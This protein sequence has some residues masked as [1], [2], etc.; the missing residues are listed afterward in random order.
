[1]KVIFSIIKFAW[2]TLNFIRDLVMNIVF[3]VFVL[4]L[5]TALPFVVGLD[6]QTVALKGDQGALYLNLDGYLADNRDNQGGVKTLLKELDNQHIPQQYSTFDVVYAIDSAALD[7]KVRGLVLD[8]NYFQGGDLPSLEFVGASIENFKKNG[9]QV[10]AYSDN[11]NRA[12]YF[13]ASY[14]DE[15]YMNPVGTVSIDGL[16]QENLYYKDLLDS[17]EVNPH[18]FRVGTY[19]SAVEP[20]LRNDMSDEAKT[21]L[22][23]WLGIMWNNYKQRV[24]ENRN[25]KEE[26]VA[27]NAHT[28]LTEL[29]ALQGDMTAYVKQRK[30]INGVLDRFNLDKKLTALFGDNEDKQP[31]MVDYDTYLASLPDRMSGD[32]KNK[33]AV[34]NVEGAIIDGETDE[35]NVGG[36]TIANLLRKAYDDKDV[37]AVV[38]RVNSPGGSAFA[39]EIIR[40]ELSH[41]QQAGKPVVV[42]MGGMAASGGYWISSTADYI[43]ADKNTITGS[44]GI[45]AV[46]PTFEKTI[47]KIGVSAD[48]VKTSDLALGSAF[49]PLS[50]ELN[51]VLQLEIEHGYD[52]FLTKVSQGRHLSKAQVDKIAQG[53]VWLGSEA[54]EHKLVDE[55]GDLNT[56]LGKAMEL[57]NEKL[58]ENSKIQ[59]EGFSVEWLDDDSGSFFKKFMRDFKGDSKAWVTGLVTEAVGLPKEFTQVK[60]LGLLNTFND[61][62]G[63]YLYCLT[64]GKVQ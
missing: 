60:Q 14:A 33:I 50:S 58:D 11:Y 62:K 23:R 59:E 64:C 2:R 19:K 7:D 55:L 1:M 29:K 16:V 37:K 54:I 4:L 25:I 13:L 36:D 35:E 53:Q 20:F 46:L 63:Q 47:K 52:E 51:D 15:V 48:G 45:F 30:L 34:V 32:T 43:V 39:S 44:I 12:Q 38:L 6:K 61:P 57:V 3:L 22:R 9:K 26:S 18:V 40:Q 31:K 8:L 49:S 24:A 56:A 41:L 42:S 17:L 27:P 5:L 10:I 21:N 28:Y